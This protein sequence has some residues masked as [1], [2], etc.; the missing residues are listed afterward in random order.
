MIESGRIGQKVLTGLGRG[1]ERVPFCLD[2]LTHALL[3]VGIK[4]PSLLIIARTQIVLWPFLL[5]PLPRLPGRLGAEANLS[6]EVH[7]GFEN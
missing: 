5:L 6:L 3:L 1:H 2:V 4:S 7:L